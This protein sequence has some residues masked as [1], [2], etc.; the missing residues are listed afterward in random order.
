MKRNLKYIIAIVVILLIAMIGIIAVNKNK[1]EKDTDTVRRIAFCIS[2]FFEHFK[3][4]ATKENEEKMDITV[5]FYN[6]GYGHDYGDGGNR[7][8]RF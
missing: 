8:G 2:I 7:T 1:K 6:N 5:T 3:T 4:K